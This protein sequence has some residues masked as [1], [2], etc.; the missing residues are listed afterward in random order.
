MTGLCFYVFLKREHSVLP[1]WECGHISGGCFFVSVGSGRRCT[2]WKESAAENEN[3]QEEEEV[4]Y[5]RCSWPPLFTDRGKQALLAICMAWP[6]FTDM[7][8]CI[9]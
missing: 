5:L 9:L 6:Y 4:L 8:V 2:E 7:R 3:H 1:N